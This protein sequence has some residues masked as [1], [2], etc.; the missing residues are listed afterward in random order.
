M[1]VALSTSSYSNCVFSSSNWNVV[2]GPSGAG[3]GRYVAGGEVQNVG[4]DGGSI[5]EPVLHVRTCVK[6]RRKSY[7]ECVIV[8]VASP[9][10]TS[11][12]SP[13]GSRLMFVTS[14]P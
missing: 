9:Y 10:A 4:G 11:V 3:G 6:R 5:G 8:A 7:I 12:T 14:V 2:G 13:S 1:S